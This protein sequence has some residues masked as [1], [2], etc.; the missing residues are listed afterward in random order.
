M[1]LTY[2]VIHI[3][4]VSVLFG[5]WLKQLSLYYF[6]DQHDNGEAKYIYLKDGEKTQIQEGALV[7]VYDIYEIKLKTKKQHHRNSSKS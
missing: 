7:K 5:V 2:V 6:F 4:H 3:T 1:F